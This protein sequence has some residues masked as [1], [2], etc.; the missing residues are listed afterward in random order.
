MPTVLAIATMYH[1]LPSDIVQIEHPFQ[2]YCFDAAAAYYQ[3]FLDKDRK[4]R[5][6]TERKS[7]PGL[8]SLL[9]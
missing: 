9:K 5:L 1:Q 2:K 7:N 6:E 4:P 3:Q 8:Q